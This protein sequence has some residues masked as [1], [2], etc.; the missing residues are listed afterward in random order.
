M[1]SSRPIQLENISNNNHSFCSLGND[2]YINIAVER[3]ANAQLIL[4]NKKLAAELNLD[5]PNS[6]DELEKLMLEN[7]AW[8]KFDKHHSYQEKS[9]T[10]RTFFS[11]RYMDSDD[12]TAGNALGDGRAIWVGEIVNELESGK[13]EYLDIVLKGTGTTELAWLNHPRESHRD[14]QLSLSEA[15]HEYIY[16]SAAKA[17]GIHVVDVLA[18]IELPFYREADNQKAAIIIRVGNHLRFAHYCYFADNA[19]QLERLFEYGLKRNMGFSLSHTVTPQDVKNYL[20]FI[21]CNLASDAAI[22]FDLHA[23]HGSPTFG[24]ITS[25]GGT[26]D[27]AT[28]I[29]TDA[30]HCNYSYMDNGA[31]LLGGEWGQKEQFFNLF[32]NLVNTLKKS[33]F[34]Y[35]A[36]ILPVEY[37][38]E[39]YNE[40][41]EQVI[42]NRWLERIG[43]S[44][45]E[46]ESLSIQ[47]KE[48]FY[49]IVKLIYELKGSKKTKF[50]KR[51]I[52]L[53][54]FEP[55]KILSATVAHI[56]DFD[57]P[58]LIWEKLFKVNRHWGSYK[59]ADAKPYIKIYQQSF[60]Q[61][62]TE[63]NPSKEVL[64]IWQRRSK[65]IRLAERNEPGNDF[66]YDTERF[67]ASEKVLQLLNSA[68]ISWREITQ[69]AELS[70]SKLADHGF[71]SSKR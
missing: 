65:A 30:H 19:A 5:L 44:Q 34:A 2:F 42:T 33:R 50:N 7:F 40:K 11:T 48:R 28:F 18:V 54:A 47:C 20:E 24:N 55:R 58:P 8:F 35:E 4:F 21:V 15:V 37:Y 31:N 56:E 14:G 51:K 13:T 43:L 67:F 66:F 6:D 59:L 61:I 62:V 39:S 70:I 1:T 38:L 68:D 60:F 23:V 25:C 71:S 69:A 32:S 22:Y 16:S 53:A 46:I 45:L 12:K 41:F 9:Q 27:F 29:Y 57:N 17:N 3:V 49:E 26:I 36:D 52:V 64:A 10:S 63:L